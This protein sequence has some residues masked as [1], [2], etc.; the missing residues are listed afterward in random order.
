MTIEEPVGVESAREALSSFL[1]AREAAEKASAACAALDAV[2]ADLRTTAQQMHKAMSASAEAL[3][4]LS[5]STT[6]LEQ[7][8]NESVEHLASTR[9]SLEEL[10]TFAAGL[11]EQV[12]SGIT[13]AVAAQS[14][15]IAG[16]V[17]RG[18]EKSVMD[19]VD[20][21]VAPLNYAVQAQLAQ[22]Q[23]AQGHL[24]KQFAE[25]VRTAQEHLAVPQPVHKM[26]SFRGKRWA[27]V[28]AIVAA[29]GWLV[30][31]ARPSAYEFDDEGI[32]ATVT[33]LAIA[34]IASAVYSMTLLVG[35]LLFRERPW[36]GTVLCV[37][38]AAAAL[39]IGMYVAL[40]VQFPIA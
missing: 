7:G 18:M 38:L 30:L 33:V 34:G 31:L 11:Q 5:E 16:T 37:P 4:A 20:R 12:R 10:S 8:S 32:Q 2:S 23:G 36:L 1:K 19:S 6:R 29:V 9:S 26:P 3:T 13:A 28:T 21:G 17:V 15:E 27:I 25:A 40:N 14:D 39:G 24:A 35:S 22:I